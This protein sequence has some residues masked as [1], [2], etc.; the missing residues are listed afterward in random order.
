LLALVGELRAKLAAALA[1]IAQLETELA[2]A[3]KNSRNPSKPPS[4]DIVK[5][6]PAGPIGGRR[7]IGAQPGR[8]RR[9]R[10]RQKNGRCPVFRACV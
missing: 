2:K 5:P 3:R 4:S 7:H 6:P 9:E 1:R 8:R 10:N